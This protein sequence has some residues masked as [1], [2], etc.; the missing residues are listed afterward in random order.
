MEQDLAIAQCF[1][2]LLPKSICRGG[3]HRPSRLF[4]E[5]GEVGF[6]YP[7]QDGQHR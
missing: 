2:T 6:I 7:D 5:V 3:I 1:H 4:L